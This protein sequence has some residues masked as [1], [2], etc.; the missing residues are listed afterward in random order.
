M[1]T[2]TT[3]AVTALTLGLAFAWPG[4]A[5]DLTTDFPAYV[6]SKKIAPGPY[7]DSDYLT[8]L[9]GGKTWRVPAGAFLA[10][11]SG[12]KTDASNAT[13]QALTNLGGMK[14]DASNAAAATART[15]LGT[16]HKFSITDY[17]GADLTGATDSTGAI[18]AANAACNAS[19]LGGTIYY[20]FGTYQVTS[21]PTAI[22]KNGCHIVAET[23]TTIKV[24]GTA[25][26]TVFSF[27]GTGIGSALTLSANALQD[28]NTFQVS[29]AAG[30]GVGGYVYFQSKAPGSAGA[31]YHFIAAIT[32][33]S[34]NNVT[35]N[36]TFPI[37]FN[38]SDTGLLVAPWT[39]LE[40]VGLEGSILI[41]GSQHS[42]G[43]LWGVQVQDVAHS[44]F[45]HIRGNHTNPGLTFLSNSYLNTGGYANIF[46]DISADDGGGSTT[47]AVFLYSETSS[48]F[49]HLA[50]RGLAGTG[51]GI[52]LQ[53]MSYPVATNI[54]SQ[55]SSDVAG[56][57]R[58][59]KIEATIGGSFSN[60]FANCSG[61]NGLAV[62]EGSQRNKFF[63][64][65]LNGNYT[66]EGLWLN[67]TN[68]NYNQFFGISAHGNTCGGCS[69]PRDIY[70]DN[71]DHYNQFYAVDVDR[72]WT[73][74][75]NTNLFS[76][77]NASTSITN[78]YGSLITTGTDAPPRPNLLVNP[79]MDIDQEH[80]GA[81]VSLGS[82]AVNGRY[83]VDGW[84]AMFTSAAGN[85]VNCLR[86]TSGPGTS[87]HSL[88]CINTGNGIVGPNDYMTA[89]QPI[90]ANLLSD[91]NFGTA[92]AKM[93]CLSG[94]VKSSIA[95]YTVGGSMTDFAG[96]STYRF[97]SITIPSANTWTQFSRCFPGPTSGSWTTNGTAGGAFLY[98]TAASGVN[99]TA[100]AG[101]W[102]GVNVYAAT[103]ISTSILSTDNASISWGDIKLEISPGPTAFHRRNPADELLLAQRYYETSY[104]TDVAPGTVGAQESEEVRGLFGTTAG[105][106]YVGVRY[107]TPKRCGLGTIVV[108]TFS[109]AS[110]A[111][112]TSTSGKVRSLATSS[113]IAVA[114]LALSGTTGHFY[115]I[116]MTPSANDGLAFHW[117]ADCR[118]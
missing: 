45:A 70:L 19:A 31:Y 93:L 68:N 96:T 17:S 7:L 27:V 112:G 38:M 14:S 46:D 5:A 114:S 115:R 9:R 28:T 72:L 44:R 61:N 102:G 89:R 60:I 37:S 90:E 106:Y 91:A 103:G 69:I 67:G 65:T 40:N 42:M 116:D 21:S 12:M 52:Q 74:G 24:T 79:S 55:C 29:S 35:I 81:S 8:L 73:N 94:W 77:L 58:N 11:L 97:P 10:G 59:I 105:S 39:P 117:A 109:P 18:S 57:G 82:G 32:H 47:N 6:A 101:G 85:A 22:T 111:G 13:S 88:K 98:L 83:I 54:S 25:A 108:S 104:S 56:V 62:A 92:S 71:G 1:F 51:W 49:A 64:L 43:A 95:N 53:G 16:G 36:N 110:G 20:P 63:G 80:A 30:L 75:D 84:Q 78:N 50:A 107:K 113:D 34:G 26:V 118:L 76:G 23:G 41:D 48:S 87:G 2:R 3:R 4:Y 66:N 33:I 15:N 100:S 86:D 99:K